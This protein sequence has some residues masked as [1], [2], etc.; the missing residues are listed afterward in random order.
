MEWM[1]ITLVCLS[2]G[3]VLVLG[4]I[5]Y[6]LYH[7]TLESSRPLLEDSV[8]TFDTIYRGPPV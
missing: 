1:T 7:M 2:S 4:L 5:Y 6:R 3:I 8:I